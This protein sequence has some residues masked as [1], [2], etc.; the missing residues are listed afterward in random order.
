MLILLLGLSYTP[1]SI[2]F[3]NVPSISKLQW[4]PFSITSSSNLEPEKL[5]VIIKGEGN[6]SKKLYHMLS[7]LD[8]H[9]LSV[10]VEGPYGPTF[11]DFLR[12][13]FQS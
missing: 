5:S 8:D 6:W 3:V 9:H 10:S 4:H 7:T 2:L 1:T 13:G 12:Y 11:T